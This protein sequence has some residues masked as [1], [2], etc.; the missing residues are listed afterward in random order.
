MDDTI[1]SGDLRLAA[2]FAVPPDA[3]P[4]A[5]GS[6]SATACPTIRVARPTV[7]TT[8]PE[9]AD[10]IARETGFVVLT[11]NFRGTGTSEGD[12]SAAGWLDDLARRGDRARARATACATV[13]LAGFGHGGTFAVCEAAVR[14]SRARRR[15]HRGAEHAARLGA[16]PRAPARPRTRDGHDP[17]SGL[18]RRRA[19]LGARG[20]R[21][22][23][24]R[25]GASDSTGARCSCSTGSTIPTSRSTTPV[26]SPTPGAPLCRA[27]AGA[28]CGPPPAPRPAGD[29]HP[30][31]L[32][33]PPGALIAPLGTAARAASSTSA[34]VRSRG[35]SGA[36]P[37]A[38][39]RRV[40]SPTRTG[41][42]QAARGR[43]R[44]T[45]RSGRSRE[46]EEALRRCRRRVTPD[47]EHTL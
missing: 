7:G 37:V 46:R 31:R 36:H 26:P 14:R 33:R 39:R 35:I 2:H 43:G 41:R 21:S 42:R 4:L 27:P 16:R 29:R 3:R 38:S 9:L 20:R 8:Y 19:A 40:A 32:A 23:R 47:P 24:G 1:L 12:F 30:A 17:H 44:P 6:C 28:G 25:G 45:S 13:W 15:D 10:H 18:P 34:S 11:F 5:S 22:R